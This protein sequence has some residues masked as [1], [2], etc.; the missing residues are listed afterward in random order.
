MFFEFEIFKTKEKN[1]VVTIPIRTN[2]S[3]DM[4]L[5]IVQNVDSEFIRLDDDNF[6]LQFN[7]A[8]EPSSD[9]Y[10]SWLYNQERKLLETII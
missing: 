7:K 10:P 4:I 3:K 8:D 9:I 6:V 2:L 1:K 5:K